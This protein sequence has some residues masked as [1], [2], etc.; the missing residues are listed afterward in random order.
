VGVGGVFGEREVGYWF[1]LGRGGRGR[2]EINWENRWEYRG[3]VGDIFDNE[4]GMV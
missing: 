1:L 2:C 4:W 3:G